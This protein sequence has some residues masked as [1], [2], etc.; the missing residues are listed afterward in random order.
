MKL[1]MFQEKTERVAKHIGGVLA[2]C[3]HCSCVIFVH[4]NDTNRFPDTGY[5]RECPAETGDH[6]ARKEPGSGVYRY[7]WRLIEN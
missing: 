3:E 2:A 1:Q 4:S 6:Y 5:W 7:F